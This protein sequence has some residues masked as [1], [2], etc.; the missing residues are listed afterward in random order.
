MDGS[1]Y[2]KVNYYGSQEGHEWWGNHNQE[3][4]IKVID[5]AFD[6]FKKEDKK[7]IRKHCIPFLMF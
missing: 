1:F 2:N 5:K 6:Y 4:T 3:I 7:W